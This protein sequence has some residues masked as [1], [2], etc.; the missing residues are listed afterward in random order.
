[1][2]RTNSGAKDDVDRTAQAGRAAADTLLD[3]LVQLL[4]RRIA[5][6]IVDEEKARSA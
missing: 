1:M 3:T 2:P 4:A 5:A 6:R